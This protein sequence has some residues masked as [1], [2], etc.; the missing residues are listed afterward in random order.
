[1]RLVKGICSLNP[2]KQY[3]LS[4]VWATSSYNS[5]LSIYHIVCWR[6]FLFYCPLRYSLKLIGSPG[7]MVAN[8]KTGVEHTNQCWFH[9]QS[10]QGTDV[11]RKKDGL[12]MLP[13]HSHHSSCHIW[14]YLKLSHPKLW[15][16]II[17][18]LHNTFLPGTRSLHQ[19]GKGV[20]P[21]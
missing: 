13:Q 12:K 21:P 10:K 15:W 11:A 4:M 7:C 1:M 20:A 5:R 14:Q 6:C 9:R 2:Q 16:R 3:S 8:R 19:Q 17:T 18:I